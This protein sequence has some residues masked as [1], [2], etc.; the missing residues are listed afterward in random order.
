MG[1]GPWC[2]VMEY[3]RYQVSVGIHSGCS[4]RFET[5]AAH[6]EQD[7][8]GIAHCLEELAI[9]LTGRLIFSWGHFKIGESLDVDG[10]GECH[11]R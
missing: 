1:C 10:I 3:W 11:E 5:S 2:H 8:I 7:G 6:Q 4:C 9:D